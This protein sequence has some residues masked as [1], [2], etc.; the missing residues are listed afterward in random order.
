MEQPIWVTDEYGDTKDIVN[1]WGLEILAEQ[2]FGDY[3]GDHAFL[4]RNHDGQIGLC[5]LGYGSCTGCDYYQHICYEAQVIGDWSAVVEHSENTLR[6]VHWENSMEE[7]MAWVEESA[8]RGFD[9][10]AYDTEAIKW[11]NSYGAHLDLPDY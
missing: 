5:V 8:D 10:W 3:Q 6:S 11:L 4:L 2:R 1:G 9:W 7:L